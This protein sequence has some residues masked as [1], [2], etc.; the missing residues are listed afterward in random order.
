MRWPLGSSR[1]NCKAVLYASPSSVAVTI[2]SKVFPVL[3][4]VNATIHS[5]TGGGGGGSGGVGGIA[6][7]FG[8][9]RFSTF[10]RL[11]PLR[12]RF[13]AALLTNLPVFLSRYRKAPF[14]FL[15]TEHPA[16]C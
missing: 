1:R 3:S 13:Q 10:S 7:G 14:F 4:Y 8:G 15:A 5:N 12:L 9:L 11:R 6:G 2:T 16:L